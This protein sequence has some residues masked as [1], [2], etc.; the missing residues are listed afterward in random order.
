MIAIDPKV[1]LPWEDATFQEGRE[2]CKKRNIY[3][4]E[5]LAAS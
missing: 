4:F 5:S 2:T 3:L 1:G